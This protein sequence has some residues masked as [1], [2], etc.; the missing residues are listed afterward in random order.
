MMSRFNNFNMKK[1]VLLATLVTIMVSCS[2]KKVVGTYEGTLPAASTPGIQTELTL[3]EDG[4]YQLVLDYMI[5]PAAVDDSLSSP[6]EQSV[7]TETG[8]YDVDNALLTLTSADSA[9]SYFQVEDNQLRML[10]SDQ[11]TVTGEMADL[12][13]LQKVQ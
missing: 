4:T 7:F 1:I 2:E 8:S 9:L 3:N 10:N 5:D 11:E 12:Y 13:V 6:A